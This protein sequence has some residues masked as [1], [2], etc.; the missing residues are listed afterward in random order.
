MQKSNFSSSREFS[1]SD[2]VTNSVRDI[3]VLRLFLPSTLYH[4]C[5]YMPGSILPHSLP[6]FNH[7]GYYNQWRRNHG[8][9]GVSGLP[10]FCSAGSSGVRAT[11]YISDIWIGGSYSILRI[12]H[13][14]ILIF[15]WHCRNIGK[16]NAFYL[17]TYL[18]TF[19]EIHRGLWP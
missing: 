17:S 14:K 15:A 12:L 6:Y 4:L 10:T 8:V 13:W 3:G 1:V 2:S 7:V 9:S 18:S 5:T 16:Y 19:I 11:V